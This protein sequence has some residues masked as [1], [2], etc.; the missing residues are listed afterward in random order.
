MF[1]V[2]NKVVIDRFGVGQSAH[3]AQDSTT[4]FWYWIAAH[5]QGFNIRV[6]W[7]LNSSVRVRYKDLY[8]E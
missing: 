6:I 1:W 4:K 7:L 5:V 2:P 8:I 3:A